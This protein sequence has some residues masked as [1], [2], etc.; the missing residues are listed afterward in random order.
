MKYSLPLAL[1]LPLSISA[2]DRPITALPYTPGIDTAFMDRSADP[3]VDFSKYACG[4][5]L[6][7]NP[8]PPDQSRWDVYGKLT[9]ENQLYLW[10]ILGEAS[11][12]NATRSADQQK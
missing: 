12:A 1:L 5:W 4:N 2:Q 3:C 7:L 10:G 11:N 9:Y 6:K 8:I